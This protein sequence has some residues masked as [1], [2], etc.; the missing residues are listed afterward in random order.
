MRI[1]TVDSFT[2]RP[3]KGNP[4][5]VCLLESP[6]SDEWMQSLASELR[7]SETAFVDPRE[8]GHPYG[9]RWFTPATE[10]DLCG[11]AT[12]AAAHV[13]YSTGAA[14][15]AI[16]FSTRSGILTTKMLDNGF[17]SMDFPAYPPSEIPAPEGLEEALGAA[18][19]WVGKGVLDLLVELESEQ[20]V[21]DLTPDIPALTG[22]DARAVC[23][24]ARA[25]TEG[26]DYVSRF[27]APKVGVPEDPVT[28]SAHCMLSPY[29]STKLGED[30]L[31]AAQ[32]SERGGEIHTTYAHPRTFLSGPATT[33]WSGDLHI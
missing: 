29:W 16:E 27:F 1:F 11:H 32:L 5:G 3:F 15:G 4:A 18:P 28:G 26:L 24:T 6:R 13:L 21:R 12:M 8:Q 7:H 20:A 14:A 9:L 10:V 23:V 25:T 17:I 19:T 31:V 33:V 22:I 30:T 2:D